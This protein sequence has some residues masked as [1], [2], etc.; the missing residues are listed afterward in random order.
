MIIVHDKI[1][2]E[3]ENYSQSNID[4]FYNKTKATQY[5]RGWCW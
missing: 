2:N 4:K 3:D 5:I 1:L